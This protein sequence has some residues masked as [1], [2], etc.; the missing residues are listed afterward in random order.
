MTNMGHSNWW[1][2]IIINNSVGYCICNAK[3][4]NIYNIIIKYYN[5]NDCFKN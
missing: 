4:M 3:K 2:I 5:F 1:T